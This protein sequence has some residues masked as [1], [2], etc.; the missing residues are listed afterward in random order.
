MQNIFLSISKKIIL[1]ILHFFPFL[2]RQN[3]SP[4]FEIFEYEKPKLWK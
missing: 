4:A 2:F 1:K 3:L